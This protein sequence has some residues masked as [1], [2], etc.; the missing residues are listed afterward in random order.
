M[1]DMKSIVDKWNK[2]P[3]VEPEPDEI[4]AIREFEAQKAA[5]TLELISLEE[6]KD[7]AARANG[8]IS[9]RVPKQLHIDLIN[10]ASDEGVSLN[11]YISYLLASNVEH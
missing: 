4:E 7:R 9:L 10:A 5:G 6:L 3:A 1:T 11:Q 2:L 8:R